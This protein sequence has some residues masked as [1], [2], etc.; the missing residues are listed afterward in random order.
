MLYPHA[1]ELL[2][3]IREGFLNS[4]HDSSCSNHARPVKQNPGEKRSAG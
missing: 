2:E 1:E 3:M 4:R